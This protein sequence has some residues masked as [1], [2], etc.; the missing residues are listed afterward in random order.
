MKCKW[1]LVTFCLVLL[2]T[3]KFSG[4]AHITGELQTRLEAMGSEEQLPVNVVLAHQAQPSELLEVKSNLSKQNARTAV[5]EFLKTMA[6]NDQMVLVNYLEEMAEK[7]DVTLIKQLWI[8]NSISIRATKEVIL[9]CATFPEVDHIALNVKKKVLIEDGWTEKKEHPAFSPARGDTAWGVL[10]IRAQE[11]W[12]EYGV[13]GEEALVAVLDTGTDYNHSDLRNRVWRNPGEIPNN[14]QDDDGNGYVDDYY[15]YDFGSHD[16]NPMDDYGHGTHVAG[17]VAGDGTGGTL[18]GVAPATTIQ[19]LKVLEYGYGEEANVWESLQ[20][21]VDNGTTNATGSIGWIHNYHNPDRPSWRTACENTVAAGVALT[22]AGGN[23][24][25]WYGPPYD[26][27]TPGDVPCV[28]G[29]GATAYKSDY[30]ASFSS[31]GPT[32]WDDYPYPPGLVKPDISAPGENVN[33]T[34]MGGGYSGDTWSGTS[35]ATPHVAGLIALMITANPSINPD[36][37]REC[38]E[39]TAIDLGSPGKDNDYGWGRVD[40]FEAVGCV[41]VGLDYSIRARQFQNIVI[42]GGTL[43]MQMTVKNY[44]ASPAT[45]WIYGEGRGRSFGIYFGTIPGETEVKYNY[46]FDTNRFHLKPGDYEGFVAIGPEVGN[47]VDTADV[48]FSIIKAGKE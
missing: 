47:P 27:R 36:F 5:S 38:L 28:M 44:T 8:V 7:G 11:A 1:I 14:S 22:F 33:S 25:N 46:A 41:G 30:Y 21:C 24:R 26:I 18:T 6:R 37:I 12:E 2:F 17:T 19:I 32:Y 42:Q 4:A 34:T 48:A 23:E 35:M 20:Y 13:K 45:G 16:S 29:I 10:W 15:G 43:S 9:H 31:E 40:A 39:T 3:P